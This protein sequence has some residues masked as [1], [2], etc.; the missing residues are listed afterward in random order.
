MY[1][2]ELRFAKVKRAEYVCK[3]QYPLILIARHS[4]HHFEK[5][6]V[7]DIFK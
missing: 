7:Y 3:Q 6:I 5:E 1:S 2:V 4:M